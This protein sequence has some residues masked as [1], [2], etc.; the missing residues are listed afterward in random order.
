MS[1]WVWTMEVQVVMFLHCRHTKT[2]PASCAE[3]KDEKHQQ[4]LKIVAVSNAWRCSLVFERPKPG[5]S[6]W[7]REGSS[8][9]TTTTKQTK[10]PREVKY[11]YEFRGQERGTRSGNNSVGH[12][13]CSGL[14]TNAGGY[15]GTLCRSCA[16]LLHANWCRTRFAS[17]TGD[18][19]TVRVNFA[20]VQ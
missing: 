14:Q 12:Q 20:C 6:G 9:Q 4:N 17:D 10:K 5:R 2:K 19:K 15:S 11:S 16:F 3:T 8:K 18:I 1:H 7:G 13:G